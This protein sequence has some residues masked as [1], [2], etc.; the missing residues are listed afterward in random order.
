MKQFCQRYLFIEHYILPIRTKLFK[1]SH[2]G[3]KFLFTMRM[4]DGTDL[5]PFYTEMADCQLFLIKNNIKI[6]F[7]T[8]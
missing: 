7:T 8:Q 5:I 2:Q 3:E 4:L 6:Y 1:M